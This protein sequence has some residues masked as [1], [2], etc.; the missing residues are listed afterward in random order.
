MLHYYHLNTFPY[1]LLA[2]MLTTEYFPCSYIHL[3]YESS[4][5]APSLSHY[6][7]PY[8]SWAA[9]YHIISC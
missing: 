7:S 6:L 4:L 9:A 3:L 2:K 5:L 8:I 1:I